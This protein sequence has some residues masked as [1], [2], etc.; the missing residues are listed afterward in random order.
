MNGTA[1][2]RPGLADVRGVRQMTISELTVAVRTRK[3]G[4]RGHPATKFGANRG[5][6]LSD[7]ERRSIEFQLR[8]EGRLP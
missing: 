6:T 5:R 7:D 4:S 3:H 8:Q 2:Y 1:A